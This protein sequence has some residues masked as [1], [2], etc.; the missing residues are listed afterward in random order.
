M[1]AMDR[2]VGN[3][4]AFINET[5]LQDVFSMLAPVTE[6]KV[7]KD[8]QS[9]LSAGYGFV[10]LVDHNNAETAM[11]ALNGAVLYGQ[12]IRVNWA[13]QS[14]HRD[15][16]SGQ[17]HIFVGDLSNEVTDQVLYSTFAAIGECTDARVM[18]DHNTGRS[19]GYGFVSFKSAD[20]AEHSIQKMNGEI[21]G[22]RRIRCGWAQHKNESNGHADASDIDRTDPTNTNV[23]VGNIAS[24]VTDAELRRHFGAYGRVV[25]LK[26]HRKGGYGFVRY[27]T[28]Q[29]AVSSICSMNGKAIGGKALKCSWGRN[30][31]SNSMPQGVSGAMGMGANTHNGNV[32]LGLA[33]MQHMI[34]TQ[35]LLAPG[36]L[37]GQPML[38]NQHHHLGLA[39]M[40]NPAMQALMAAGQPMPPSAMTMGMQQPVMMQT[41]QQPP[42]MAQ[43][44]MLMGN[45][46][47]AALAMNHTNNMYYGMYYK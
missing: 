22:G 3:L 11:N 40:A 34:N 43:Q 20:D 45:Q 12:E 15:D 41:M 26:Q 38:M 7:I 17:S 8:R 42:L 47:G 21:L 9:G 33:G 36:L 16:N 24:E 10:K 23:Y 29:E 44:G 13:F 2:Y 27:Q 37:N 25:E 1:A 28:H 46:P 30:T 6:A 31:S 39:S 32:L 19:K 14:N 4:H 5:V 35:A 18:W